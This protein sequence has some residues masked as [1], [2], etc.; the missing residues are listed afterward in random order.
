MFAVHWVI[1]SEVF[2]L[3]PAWN[4]WE[5]NNL[6][7]IHRFLLKWGIKSVIR[8]IDHKIRCC[9]RQI[10]LKI[11]SVICILNEWI[12]INKYARNIRGEFYNNIWNNCLSSIFLCFLFRLKTNCRNQSYECWSCSPKHKVSWWF[13]LKADHSSY[14]SFTSNF[15][16]QTRLLATGKINLGIIMSDTNINVT[17]IKCDTYDHLFELKIFFF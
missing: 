2:T 14:W 9:Y 17:K 1:I 13:I 8:T 15:W 16:I 6:P 5:L 10:A 7:F 11:G 3:K 4:S 12:K